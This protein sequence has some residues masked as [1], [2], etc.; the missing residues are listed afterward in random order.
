M[1]S[2]VKKHNILLKQ[3][4]KPDVLPGFTLLETLVVVII[5]GVLAAIASPAWSSL[6]NKQ[7]LNAAK[8]E[9]FQAIRTA[10]HHAKLNHVDWQVSF[11]E[12]N[13][14]VQWVTHPANAAPSDSLWHTLDP[15]VRI[16][17]ETT[18]YF[19]QTNKIY[20]MRFTH[21]GRTSGQ[22]G[23]ITFSGK[24]DSKIKRC[25]IVSTLLGA[26]REGEE[27]TSGNDKPCN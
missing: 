23:R 1:K 26:M 6:L 22:L 27:Q 5:I 17:P 3:R 4:I 19:D 11:R 24:T 12:V 25:V 7:R 14:L 16:N 18:F 15:N 8:N 20:R 21:L 9:A 10:Q 13:G 2:C